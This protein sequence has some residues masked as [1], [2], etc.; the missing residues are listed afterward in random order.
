EVIVFGGFLVIRLVVPDAEA[1]EA[2]GD[3]GIVG[4][5]FDLVAGVLL[6]DELVVGFVFVQGADEVIAVAPGVGFFT[7]ALVAVGL[8]VANDV[9]PEAG[10]AL[11]VAGGGEEVIDHFL[12]S[13]IRWIGG[14]TLDFF[15]GGG[16]SPE[17]EI[18]AADEF[19]F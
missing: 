18:G 14:E 4:D 2:G 7:V 9:E 11:A 19:S 10:P 3:E 15:W 8:G 6:A 12:E 17:V 5:V 13:A 1:P 16:K